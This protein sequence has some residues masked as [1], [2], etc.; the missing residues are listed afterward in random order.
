MDKIKLLW[1]NNGISSL[2]SIVAYIA[3]D[4]DYYASAFAGKIFKQIYIP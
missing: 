3:E 1:S 4:S 2:E